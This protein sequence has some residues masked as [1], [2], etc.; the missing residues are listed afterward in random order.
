VVVF[1]S[2]AGKSTT[3]N[4]ERET[5]QIPSLPKGTGSDPTKSA[6]FIPAGVDLRGRDPLT[7]TR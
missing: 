4:V 3:L 7:V 5:K 1:S 6:I 2:A